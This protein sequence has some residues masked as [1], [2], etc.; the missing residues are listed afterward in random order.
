MILFRNYDETNHVDRAWYNSSNVIFSEC[1]DT[2]NSLKTLKVVFKNGKQYQYNDV[3]VNDYVMFMH[4]GL[5]GSNGK[6]LSKYIIKKYECEKLEDANL[7]E[8][9]VQMI[10][11]QEQKDTEKLPKSN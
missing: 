3:D 4:G 8:L 9:N 11:L 5:D 7:D 2:P 1:I 10:K 6:A